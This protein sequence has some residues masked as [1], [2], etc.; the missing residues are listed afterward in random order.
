MYLQH[1]VRLGKNI[2]DVSKDCEGDIA[3]TLCYPVTKYVLLYSPKLNPQTVLLGKLR[4]SSTG[5]KLKRNSAWMPKLPT[6]L[7][8]RTKSELTLTIHST[9]SLTMQMIMLPNC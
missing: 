6:L 9:H 5:R 2:Y 1:A 7:H 4:N 3:D 8:A